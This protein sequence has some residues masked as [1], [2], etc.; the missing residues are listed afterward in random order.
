M[1]KYT[2]AKENKKWSLTELGFEIG[3]IRAKY[4]E[5][6]PCRKQYEQIVPEG[7][8]EKGYVKEVDIC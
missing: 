4:E 1:V 2:Y 5:N 6:S 3:R 7:W 8:V